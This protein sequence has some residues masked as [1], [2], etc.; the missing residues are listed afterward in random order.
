M[1]KNFKFVCQ[2]F[3]SQNDVRELNSNSN[4]LALSHQHR[5]GDAHDWNFSFHKQLIIPQQISHETPI[6]PFKA[7][8]L[9]KANLIIFAIMLLTPVWV[10]CRVG[11]WLALNCSMKQET[12]SSQITNYRGKMDEQSSSCKWTTFFFSPLT[13]A[14]VA[15]ALLWLLPML[16][17]TQQVEIAA[18]SEDA[19]DDFYNTEKSRYN[20]STLIFD[21]A[22]EIVRWVSCGGKEAFS[23]CRKYK[24]YV[25]CSA[26]DKIFRIQLSLHYDE[27]LLELTRGWMTF[28]WN[29]WYLIV[30]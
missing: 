23:R 27:F 5:H 22:Q 15:K 18:V 4:S 9:S 10:V 25:E 30:R 11:G 12:W 24:K 13:R 28:E 8:K 7:R 3:K 6:N 20:S 14:P 19:V 2:D 29:V 16:I 26:T 17:Q 1:E 21:I